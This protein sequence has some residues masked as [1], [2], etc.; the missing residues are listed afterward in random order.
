MAA[1]TVHWGK[2]ENHLGLNRDICQNFDSLCQ[3]SIDLTGF[4]P[5]REF[6]TAAAQQAA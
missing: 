4:T 3:Q 6:R 5:S 1:R 2:W